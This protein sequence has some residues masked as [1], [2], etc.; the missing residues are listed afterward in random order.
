MERRIVGHKT[1]S[2]CDGT[3]VTVDVEEFRAGGISND[4]IHK[5]A[6]QMKIKSLLTKT[7]K[8]TGIAVEILHILTYI[9]MILGRG[10][11]KEVIIFH[12]YILWNEYSCAQN[13]STPLAFPSDFYRNKSCNID[14]CVKIR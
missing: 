10:S 14:C 13:Y 7:C 2:D 3:T 6:L 11:R 4:G 5:F 12:K 1:L 9:L 8:V